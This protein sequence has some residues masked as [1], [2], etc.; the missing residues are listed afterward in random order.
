MLV[1]VGEVAPQRVVRV[2][3]PDGL[4]GQCL[5]PPRAEIVVPVTAILDVYLHAVAQ[6]PGML[7]EGR[8]EP[9][10]AQPAAIQ[11]VWGQFLHFGDHRT[12][13]DIRRAE[14]FERARR[15]PSFRQRGAFQHDRSSVT[16][17]HRQVGC[18][19]A[20]V[21]PGAF[22]E[23]PAK[24]RRSLGLPAVHGDYLAFD[25]EPEFGDEPACQLTHRQPVSHRQGAGTDEAFPAGAQ[26]QTL[27][28]TPRRIRAIQHP[29]PLAVLRR[30][31]EHVAQGGDERVDTAA[32]I[33]QVDQ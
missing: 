33:L 9:A 31:F 25:I 8:L 22:A 2:Q 11:P 4:E 1:L 10:V 3:P 12:G 28:R 19:R 15:A 27:D 17:C 30:G 26:R 20:G 16:A 14:Q 32:E 5:Q 21:D 24:T 7:V 13:V 18:V 23:R 6:L 29:H